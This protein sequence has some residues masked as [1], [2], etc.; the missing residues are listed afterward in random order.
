M[1]VSPT[2]SHRR[3]SLMYQPLSKLFLYNKLKTM[4]KFI[5]FCVKKNCIVFSYYRADELYGRYS[6]WQYSTGGSPEVSK[7]HRPSKQNLRKCNAV[8]DVSLK[9]LKGCAI[10][11]NTLIPLILSSPLSPILLHFPYSS[12]GFALTGI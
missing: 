4:I 9:I 1:N 11:F 10:L 8:L 3:Q 2:T 6:G 7:V 5:A 12:Y